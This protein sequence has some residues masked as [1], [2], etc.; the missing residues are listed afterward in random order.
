MHYQ[1]VI[2]KDHYNGK[3]SYLRVYVPGVDI[4]DKFF[5]NGLAKGMLQL[6]DGRQ[7]SAAQRGLLYSLFNDIRIWR[8]DS[9]KKIGVEKVKETLKE[10]F[11]EAAKVS[12]FSL[13]NV[14]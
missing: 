6:D 1:V 10:S 8:G 9:H 11:C 3:G 13:S 4:Q 7:L 14:S 5:M 12:R 2:K